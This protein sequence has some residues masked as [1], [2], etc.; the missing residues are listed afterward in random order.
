MSQ[1]KPLVQLTGSHLLCVDAFGHGPGGDDV[2]HHTFTQALGNLVELQEV[3][4][5]VEHL[6]VAVGVGVHL[7]KDGGH[8]SKN[9]G[10]EQ[11]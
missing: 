3:P 11:R 1:Q 10:I 7:L 5:V 8:V 6:V 9:G 2:V 4:D